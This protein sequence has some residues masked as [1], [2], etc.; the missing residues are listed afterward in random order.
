MHV[1]SQTFQAD[2]LLWLTQTNTT[3][4]IKPL[5]NICFVSGLKNNGLLLSLRNPGKVTLDFR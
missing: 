2:F 5:A 1:L 4:A 3:Q